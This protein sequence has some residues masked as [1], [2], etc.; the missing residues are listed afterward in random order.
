MT[1]A[2][3]KRESSLLSLRTPR[4]K[5][6]PYSRRTCLFARLRAFLECFRP[7]RGNGHQVRSCSPCSQMFP[8]FCL[9]QITGLRRW[10]T[11]STSPLAQSILSCILRTGG[12]FKRV[13]RIHRIRFRIAIPRQQKLTCGRIRAALGKFEPGGVTCRT[14]VNSSAA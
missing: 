9:A 3:S 6:S 14:L 12:Q 4:A 10:D 11:A 1:P 2:S 5:P 7:R 8:G 13:F